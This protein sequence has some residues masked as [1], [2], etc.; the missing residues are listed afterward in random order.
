MRLA[1]TGEVNYKKSDTHYATVNGFDNAGTA[2]GTN[3]YFSPACQYHRR[4]IF[5]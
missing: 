5:P 3:E 1:R 4:Y 2:F